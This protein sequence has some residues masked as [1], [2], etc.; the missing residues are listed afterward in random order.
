VTAATSVGR[1]GRTGCWLRA[2]ACRMSTP[3][4]SVGRR[5][6]GIERTGASV[7][8]KGV[9]GTSADSQ[10]EV[11]GEPRVLAVAGELP[12]ASSSATTRVPEG[13]ICFGGVDGGDRRVSRVGV[14]LAMRASS[15]AITSAW[16]LIFVM[17]W[18]SSS[19]RRC[20]RSAYSASAAASLFAPASAQFAAAT[21]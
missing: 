6:Y 18:A 16:R 12:V 1:S 7:C 11:V 20:S 10:S 13:A 9:M 15:E 2:M 4:R 8:G 21:H 14:N 5:L 19:S 3:T 17:Y